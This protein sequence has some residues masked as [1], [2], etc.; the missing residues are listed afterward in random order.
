LITFTIRFANVGGR[1]ITN[2]VVSDSLTTRFEYVAGS[3]KS[4]RPA[5]FTTQPN[6][7]G[8]MVL[9]WEFAGSLQP[10]ENGMITFQVK[11]R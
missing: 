7:A 6:D 1:P 4:D 5:T 8:S 2:V 9:R 3:S 10:G 11:I